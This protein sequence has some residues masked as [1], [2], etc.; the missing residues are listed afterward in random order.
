MCNCG[1]KRAAQPRTYGPITQ[2]FSLV[3]R[4]GTTQSFGSRLEADAENAR[5]GYTGIVKPVG[6]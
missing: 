6:S 2:S 4:D 1:K 3:K 5:L